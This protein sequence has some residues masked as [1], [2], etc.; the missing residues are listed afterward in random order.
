MLPWI[1]SLTTLIIGI[2]A[3][4]NAAEWV[5]AHPNIAMALATLGA[6]ITAL[7]RSPVTPARQ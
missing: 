3:Q 5:A 7:T 1:P 4:F 6:V 2:L